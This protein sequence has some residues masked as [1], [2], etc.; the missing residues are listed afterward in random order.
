MWSFISLTF[1]EV[2]ISV[3]E[4]TTRNLRFDLTTFVRSVSGKERGLRP[5]IAQLDGAEFP[6]G[7]LGCC[8]RGSGV[9]HEPFF[10]N[11]DV[12]SDAGDGCDYRIQYVRCVGYYVYDRVIRRITTFYNERNDKV[13]LH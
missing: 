13:W 9:V 7:F 3:I 11:K 5:G 10:H 1:R 4:R 8:R 2:K 6:A 12:G